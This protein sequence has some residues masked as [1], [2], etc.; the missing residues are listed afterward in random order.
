[1]GRPPDAEAPGSEVVDFYK[2]GE[3]RQI[4]A[5]MLVALGALAL[6]WFAS[7]LR[8]ILR[9]GE[10]GSGRV[11]NIAF[12]GGLGSAVGFWVAAAFH[13]ALADIGDKLEEGAA[14]ALNVL[15]NDAWAAFVPGLALMLLAT[16]LVAR[17]TG[18]LPAWLCW[19]AIVLFVGS[20]TPV[21]FVAFML[22]GLW[23]IVVSVL[24]YRAQPSP[25]SAPSGAMPTVRTA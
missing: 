13:I 5:A 21:G 20:F 8:G 23:I 15:D 18:V 10:G 25:T 16:G 3:G 17:R 14:Q 1:M 2:D 24:L 4:M 19:V 11:S 12:A 6:V 7:T 22:S 9:Q